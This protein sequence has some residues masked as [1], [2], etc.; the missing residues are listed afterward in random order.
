MQTSLHILQDNINSSVI[1]TYFATDIVYYPVNT[2]KNFLPQNSII[3][4]IQV[5]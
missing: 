3:F 5:Q 2:Y 4:P 1:Q